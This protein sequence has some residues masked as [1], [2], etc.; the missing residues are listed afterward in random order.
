VILCFAWDFRAL[1]SGSG[2]I[3]L[4]CLNLSGLLIFFCLIQPKVWTDFPL[5]FALEVSSSDLVYLSLFDC[6]DTTQTLAILLVCPFVIGTKLFSGASCILITLRTMDNHFQVSSHQ[7]YS[8][9]TLPTPRHF[10]N[11]VNKF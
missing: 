4:A 2:L 3:I 9:R 5:S 6:L 11:V 7:Q 1:E 8:R 10:F